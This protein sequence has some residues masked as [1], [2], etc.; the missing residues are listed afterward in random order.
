MKYIKY[1]M[2][3]VMVFAVF[4]ALSTF[5]TTYHFANITIPALEGTWTSEQKRKS[6]EYTQQSFTNGGA[7]DALGSEFAIKGQTQAMYDGVGF[8]SWVA[9]DVGKSAS[10]GNENKT[11][12]EY[13]LHLKPNRFNG[14]S[15]SFT[16]SWTID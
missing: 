15:I 2:F 8:S 7:R 1:S 3:L 12:N 13:K 5:A 11:P 6:L 9:V 14:L 16:G 4:G 10:W